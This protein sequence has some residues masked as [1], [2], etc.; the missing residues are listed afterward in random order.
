MISARSITPR[1][2]ETLARL[3][4]GTREICG[5]AKCDLQIFVRVEIGNHGKSLRFFERPE[6]LRESI[7]FFKSIS[8][9][10][11]DGIAW[12][13]NQEMILR[14]LLEPTAKLANGFLAVQNHGRAGAH[15]V[16]H[17]EN[18]LFAFFLHG[19][20]IKAIL[21]GDQLQGRNRLAACAK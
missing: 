16:F 7:N 21:A 10:D 6:S 14:L 9:D 17:G 3:S 4:T 12:P 18:F 8:G 2:R 5:L 15:G 1:M 11:S 20:Q 13:P 19:G